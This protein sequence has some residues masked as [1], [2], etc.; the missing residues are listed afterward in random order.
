MSF[1]NDEKTSSKNFIIAMICFMAIMF[2]YDYFTGSNP[3][4]DKKEQRQTEEVEDEQDAQDA[5]IISIKDALNSNTRVSLENDHIA[6]TVDLNGG[7]IDSV[8]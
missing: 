6:G 2:G 1:N 7:I 4:V 5:K 3:G 8:I